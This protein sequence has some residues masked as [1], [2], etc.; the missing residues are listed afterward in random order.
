MFSCLVAINSSESDE[1]TDGFLKNGDSLN[2]GSQVAL[3]DF[4]LPSDSNLYNFVQWIFPR[5]KF[6]CNGNIRSWKLRVNLSGV[7]FDSDN[8]RPIPQI[9]TW[10]ETLPE[11]NPGFYD[12]QSITNETQATV[13]ITDGGTAYVYTPS[14]PIPVQ[15]GDIL[16]IMM[17][18]DE[19][20][21]MQS[22][23]SFYLNLSGSNASTFSC[24]RVTDST[25]IFLNSDS[26]TIP[27]DEESVYIPMITAII[28]KS[29]NFANNQR[30]CSIINVYPFRIVFINNLCSCCYLPSFYWNSKYCGSDISS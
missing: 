20:E 25:F 23:K 10:R 26:C 4:S 12:Q 21:R 13:T 18:T 14:Q 9:T 2:V 27:E 17:P 22:V 5:V 30:H 3:P 6:T 7:E 16:G 11:E 29:P 1:C 28:G 8:L 19:D 15:S 24:A